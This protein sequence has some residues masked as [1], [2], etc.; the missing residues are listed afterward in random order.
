MSV[1]SRPDGRRMRLDTFFDRRPLLAAVRPTQ[2][3]INRVRQH[4]G[5]T[6]F[7]RHED[8]PQRTNSVRALSELRSRELER[9]R[10]LVGIIPMKVKG[11]TAPIRT[12]ATSHGPPLPVNQTAAPVRKLVT[13]SGA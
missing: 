7:A 4:K 8:I 10:W 2:Q 6:V 11:T 13:A 1:V 9:S 3:A 5:S 12:A